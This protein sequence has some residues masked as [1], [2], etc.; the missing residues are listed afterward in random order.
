MHHAVLGKFLHEISDVNSG[1]S[2]CD[3]VGSGDGGDGGI[4]VDGSD[5]VRT[6]T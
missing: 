6:K 1:D 5:G 2:S 4:Y 3:R